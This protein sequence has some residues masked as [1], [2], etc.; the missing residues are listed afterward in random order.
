MSADR[1]VAGKH[2]VVERVFDRFCAATRWLQVVKAYEELDGAVDDESQGRRYAG[3]PTYTVLLVL[4]A[5]AFL[6]YDQLSDFRDIKVWMR[7]IIR[8]IVAELNSEDELREDANSLATKIAAIEVLE[9]FMAVIKAGM[10]GYG[11]RRLAP[12]LR[13][14]EALLPLEEVKC[15]NCECVHGAGSTHWQPT[16]TL[17]RVSK[18]SRPCSLLY[19]KLAV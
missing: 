12:V 2:T 7:E 13:Q 11:R 19:K 18:I 15:L 14:A 17:N 8:S 9:I 10:R 6:P 1:N 5:C 4:Y 3:D 16:D